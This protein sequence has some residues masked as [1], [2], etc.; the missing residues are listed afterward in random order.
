MAGRIQFTHRKPVAWPA[1]FF[2]WARECWRSTMAM[3]S[4]G[5]KEQPAEVVPK[6]SRIRFL[7]RERIPAL[8]IRNAPVHCP[9]CGFELLSETETVVCT[10][11]SAHV[12]HAQCS[13]ELVRGKCPLD[14][15]ALKAAR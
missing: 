13:I 11:N 9:A 1:R 7:N 6:P 12:V 8:V 15:A 5:T 3:L 2:A 14:G 10:M 4:G